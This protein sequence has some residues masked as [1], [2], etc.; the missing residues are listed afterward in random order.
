MRRKGFLPDAA[1]SE[2]PAPTPAEGPTI[3]ECANLGKTYKSGKLEVQALRAVDL[4]VKKN[5]FGL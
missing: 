2:Q 3:I 5:E 4:T 1:A